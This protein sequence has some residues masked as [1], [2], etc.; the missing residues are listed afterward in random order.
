MVEAVIIRA[1]GENGLIDEVEL[2]GPYHDDYKFPYNA[3]PSS[4][5]TIN[6]TARHPKKQENL[7][8]QYIEIEFTNE[9]NALTVLEDN[10]NLGLMKIV[11]L[12]SLSMR[13]YYLD[14][15]IE[16][17]GSHFDFSFDCAIFC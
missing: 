1:F 10:Q 7:I 8:T 2:V 6:F 12:S 5:I 3:P 17:R 9:C 14:G 11:S 16:R 13:F 4:R 15:G